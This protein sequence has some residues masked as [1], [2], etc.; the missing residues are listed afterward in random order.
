M[1][2][3]VVET[4]RRFY[5]ANEVDQTVRDAGGRTYVELELR[6]AWVWD[7][8]RTSRFVQTVRIVT[9]KDVNVEELPS[10]DVLGGRRPG[11]GAPRRSLGGRRGE[12][13]AA[14]WY[15]ARGYQVVARNWRCREGELDLVRRADAGELVFCEVKTRSSDRFGVPA[16]AVT[17]AK[18]R[19]L[20]A[21]RRPLPRRRAALAGA[22]PRG[23][24]TL[25]FD[26][27]ARPGRPG[28][29]H[30]GRVLSVARR[31]SAEQGPGHR[32]RRT[33]PAPPATRRMSAGERRCWRN[34]LRPTPVSIVR[35]MGHVQ[36]ERDGA[37]VTVTLSNPG[38]K[39]AIP[40]AGLAR[41]RGRVP[42][43]GD[44]AATIR[45]V[46]LTGEGDDFCSGADVSADRRRPAATQHALVVHALGVGRPIEALHAVP[47]PVVARVAGVCVGAGLNIALGCDL[48]VA[49]DDA[50]FSEIFARRGPQH[51][52]RRLVGPAP[53]RRPAQGQGAGPARRHRPGRRGRAPR[54]GQPGGAPRRPRRHR[55]RPGRPPGR[56]PAARPEHDQAPAQPER[57]GHPRPGARGRGPGP[58]RQLRHPRHGRGDAGLRRAAGS[59]RFEGR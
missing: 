4:E 40:S 58:G 21:A 17:P 55:R 16:E 44:H 35:R 7:M 45:C 39:N 57:P 20:R 53:D 49:S 15:V 42:R 11:G 2:S 34:G 3:Y 33:R 59:R 24:R 14:D 1:F 51:R 8:Y 46:V 12:Q 43:G 19:R 52:R 9:F 47:Q 31:G 32:A 36:V 25:R 30:R 37:V 23:R 18:Q 48:V 38:K 54:A 5:L 27:A 10:K 6:D 56:R 22:A 41:A 29:G 13:L 50:R 26:V 28:R